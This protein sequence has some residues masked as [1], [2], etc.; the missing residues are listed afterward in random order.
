MCDVFFDWG[1]EH[2]TGVYMAYTYKVEDCLDSGMPVIQGKELLIKG[3]N[4]CADRC[5]EG[6]S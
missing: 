2:G 6:Q 5:L 1:G 4:A 3:I